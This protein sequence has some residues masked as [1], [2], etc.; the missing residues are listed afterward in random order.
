MPQQN[1]VAFA[2]D[3]KMVNYVE[4][5]IPYFERDALQQIKTTNTLVNLVHVFVP[6]VDQLESKV[7]EFHLKVSKTSLK[8]NFGRF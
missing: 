6:A 2:V 4:N 5:L 3:N 7:E 8:H 1:G